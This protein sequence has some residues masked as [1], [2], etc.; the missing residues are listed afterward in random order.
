MCFCGDMWQYYNFRQHWDEFLFA[1]KSNEYAQDILFYKMTQEYGLDTY[2]RGKPLWIYSSYWEDE[3][4]RKTHEHIQ[5]HNILPNFR[6]RMKEIFPQRKMLCS[7]DSF[8]NICYESLM[9]DNFPKKDSLESFICV[10]YD[11]TVVFYEVARSLFP[12]EEVFLVSN[13]SLILIP[14]RKLVFDIN[15]YYYNTELE[16]DYFY[17]YL[18]I[19]EAFPEDE[20][21][22]D[23]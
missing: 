1:W 5:T 9:E 19:E 17:E 2:V 10:S 18:S 23:F 3:I 12:N 20:E 21:D 8:F 22:F 14:M 4:Y 15:G 11:L 13:E 7:H 16:S 6:K